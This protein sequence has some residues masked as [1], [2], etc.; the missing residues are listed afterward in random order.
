MSGQ[1]PGGMPPASAPPSGGKPLQSSAEKAHAQVEQDLA[2]ER[3]RVAAQ[4]SGMSP[5]DWVRSRA[6]ATKRLYNVLERRAVLARMKA[7]PGRTYLEQAEIQGVKNG[8]KL[9]TTAEIS[10]TGK[11]RI[12]DILELDGPKATLEDLKSPSTQLKSVKGGMSSPDL[13]VE[14]RSS[15]EI[16]KQHEVEQQVI[17]EAKRTGGKVIVTGRDPVGGGTEE[18]ALDPDSIGSRVTDYTDIGNN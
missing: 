14:F 4:K 9:T 17:A 6:G 11:G 5:Q 2:A 12:A 1:G 15:S 16:A 13:E 10:K 7:F 18:L 3:S 8:G